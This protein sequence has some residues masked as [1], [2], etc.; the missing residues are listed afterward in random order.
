MISVGKKVVLRVGI[1]LCAMAAVVYAADVLLKPYVLGYR[2]AGTIKDR[3]AVVKTS[4]EKAGFQVVGE[5]EPYKGVHI[6]VVTNEALRNNAAQSSFGGYG[7]IQRIAL[8]ETGSELQIA[9]TNPLYMAQIYQMKNDL[10][11]VAAKMNAALGKVEEFGSKK[12]MKAAA[13]RD[14]HYTLGMPYFEDQIKLASYKSYDEAVQAVEAGLAKGKGGTVKVYRVDIPGKK[15]TVFGVGIKEGK[16]ADE[17][18][19]KVIDTAELRQTPHL[20]YELVVSD[21]NV[22]MLHGRFRIAQ[23]FPDLGMGTFMK[24]VGAPPGI[25]STLKQVAGGQ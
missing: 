15:E 22:Y 12:G 17:A 14:Y 16:G 20:P 7:A 19:M 2:G 3:L 18:V 21:G 1:L 23:S 13:L 24:I 4:I 9:Y 10:A 8:S 11:D 6:V 25:Q 5:Y